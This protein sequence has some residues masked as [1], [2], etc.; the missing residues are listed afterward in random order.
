MQYTHIYRK[1]NIYSNTFKKLKASVDGRTEKKR[2][3]N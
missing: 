2:R 1:E 3:E